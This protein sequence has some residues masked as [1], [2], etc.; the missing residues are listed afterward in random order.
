MYTQVYA[1]K[2]PAEVNK[3]FY[4]FHFTAYGVEY[5]FLIGS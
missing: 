5:E 2:L 1:K 3:I 4:K